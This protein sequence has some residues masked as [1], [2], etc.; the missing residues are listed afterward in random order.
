MPYAAGVTLCLPL[1]R[2]SGR[3]G[4]SR[5]EG[6]DGRPNSSIFRFFARIKKVR[7]QIAL[8]ALQFG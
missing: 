8:V 7:T 4:G 3:N 2:G 6:N 5:D 1:Q